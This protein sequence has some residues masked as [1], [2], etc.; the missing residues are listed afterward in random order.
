MFVSK[1]ENRRVRGTKRSSDLYNQIANDLGYKI[2]FSYVAG[3]VWLAIMLFAMVYLLG[4]YLP[5][6][7][8]PRTIG[9]ALLFVFVVFSLVGWLAI[10]YVL[11]RVVALWEK[12]QIKN[13]E[14]SER[15]K[16]RAEGSTASAVLDGLRKIQADP[17][18]RQQYRDLE[19]DGSALVQAERDRER[20][21]R[22]DE[23]P[24]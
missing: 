17:K 3:G 2:A 20:E 6:D 13:H 15:L 10:P 18:L 23:S 14:I 12:E 16:A 4:P 7:Q 5:S 22:E 24:A 8:P 21:L 1:S 9:N 19:R 11:G